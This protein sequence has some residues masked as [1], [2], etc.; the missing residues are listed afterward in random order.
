MLKTL[1]VF[2]HLAMTRSERKNPDG[3]R[4][5]KQ[6][7]FEMKLLDHLFR[8]NV[9]VLLLGK[10]LL[11]ESLTKYTEKELLKVLSADLHSGG[12]QKA[13][14]KRNLYHLLTI[15]PS[16]RAKE[17]THDLNHDSNIVLNLILSLLAEAAS[18]NR[19]LR[20]IIGSN[21]FIWNQTEIEFDVKGETRIIHGKICVK[22]AEVKSSIYDA[23]KAWK[24]LVIRTYCVGITSAFIHDIPDIQLIGMLVVHIFIWTVVENGQEAH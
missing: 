11:G 1:R 19:K 20:N 4:F 17:Y 16:K 6:H 10:Y 21:K 15:E 8:P 18:K 12:P 13:R 9:T 5:E 22:T 7:N 3:S 2:V 14:A 24:Q 23:K